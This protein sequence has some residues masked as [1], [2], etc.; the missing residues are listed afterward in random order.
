MEIL[1]I[2]LPYL[3][4]KDA[5]LITAGLRPIRSN[6]IR[7]E[8]EK[9]KS[10]Y[11][12]FIFRN[13]HIYHNYGHGGAGVSLAPGCAKM[14]V[15]SFER[16]YDKSMVNE[17]AVLGSGYMGLFTA[18]ILAEKGFNVTLYAQNFPFKKPRGPCYLASEAAGVNLYLKYHQ[19]YWMPYNYGLDEKDKRAMEFHDLT[20][21]M[22]FDYY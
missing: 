22:S 7:F 17:I 5:Q 9:I 14:A 18:K 3:D 10:F 11:I 6:G 4:M 19:G 13:K 2:N 1:K 15:L 12:Y 8:E 16:S 21:R 20:S